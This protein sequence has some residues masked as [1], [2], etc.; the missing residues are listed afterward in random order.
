[1]E[2]RKLRWVLQKASAE[3]KR[4]FYAE[5]WDT[6]LGLPGRGAC[7]LIHPDGGEV[8]G[9]PPL[10]SEPGAY[11]PKSWVEVRVGQQCRLTFLPGLFWV[12]SLE[13]DDGLCKVHLENRHGFKIEI[14]ELESLWLYFGGDPESG[15]DPPFDNLRRALAGEPPRR[16][17]L[18]P[19]KGGSYGVSWINL[20]KNVEEQESRPSPRA[21]SPEEGRAPKAPGISARSFS[22]GI[23]PN[24]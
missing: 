18:K 11:Q 3:D 23:D 4:R 13:K 10:D 14:R 5:A 12:R 1:M 6:I 19:Y 15:E 16:V 8:G 7:G 17:P 20:R 24:G 22:L 9:S 21:C 2:Q